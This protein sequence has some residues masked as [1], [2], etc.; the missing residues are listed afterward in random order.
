M[1]TLLKLG[2]NQNVCT[3]VSYQCMT[4]SIRIQVVFLPM[5]YAGGPDSSAAGSEEEEYC[6]GQRNIAIRC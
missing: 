1:C 4:D 5:L 2:A 3:E 6:Y